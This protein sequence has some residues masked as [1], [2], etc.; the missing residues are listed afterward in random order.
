M[1][2]RRGSRKGDGEWTRSISEIDPIAIDILMLPSLQERF[3]RLESQRRRIIVHFAEIPASFWV[4]PPSR[5]AWPLASIAHHL[6][7][8][9]EDAMEQIRSTEI[10]QDARRSLRERFGKVAVG[11]VLRH[12]FRVPIP[13]RRLVPSPRFT[14]KEIW[15]SW[16]S[17]REELADYLEEVDEESLGRMI[18]MHPVSGRMSIETLLDFI[19]SHISHH[20]RQ[21]ARTERALGIIT[22]PELDPVVGEYN[23]DDE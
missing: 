11:L 21:V 13:P 16:D 1:W 12:G 23:N 9:E 3:E 5:G 4:T 6:L 7:L 17:V 2:C 20:M 14:F 10:R 22:P 18:Y 8:V 19:G 15:S